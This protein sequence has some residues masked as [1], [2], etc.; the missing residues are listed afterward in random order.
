MLYIIEIKERYL[1]IRI[2]V[3]ATLVDFD[4]LGE[5]DSTDSR[6]CAI[7]LQVDTHTIKQNNDDQTTVNVQKKSQLVQGKYLYQVND[8]YMR[9]DS[10]TKYTSLEKRETERKKV[11]NS[12][13][14]NSEK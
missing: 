4:F 3:G 9:R 10:P 5:C 2:A 14:T 7:V 11:R 6:L 13:D 8:L 1:Q 12:T